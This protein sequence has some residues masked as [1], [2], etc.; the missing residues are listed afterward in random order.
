MGPEE[1]VEL[2]EAEQYLPA[3]EG[4]VGE[5]LQQQVARALARRP[6]ERAEAS[7]PHALGAVEEG[8]GPRHDDGGGKA[9]MTQHHGQQVG[10][11][12]GTVEERA[13]R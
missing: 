8:K 9:A 1:Q 4:V 5:G 3:G 2:V 11:T 7:R 13:E 10:V 12:V 6:D